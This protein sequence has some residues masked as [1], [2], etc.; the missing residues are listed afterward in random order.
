MR[1]RSLLWI[2]RLKDEER[3]ALAT[4]RSQNESLLRAGASARS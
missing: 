1:V 3:R 4:I 2:K